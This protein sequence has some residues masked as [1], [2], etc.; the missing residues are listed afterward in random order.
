MDRRERFDSIEEAVRAFVGGAQAE[1]WTALPGVVQSFDAAERTCTVQ[2]AVQALARDAT[3]GN[4]TWLDLPLLLDCPVMFP[5]GG[6]VTLTFPVKQG[7]ECLVIF[8]SR[9]IDAW[10]QNG[11]TKNKQ[12]ILRMHD[13][14][15][16]FVFVGIRSKAVIAGRNVDTTRAMLTTDDGTAMVAITAETGLVEVHTDNDIDF[17]AANIRMKGNVHIEGDFST[18][19]AFTN[20]GKDV[21]SVHTHDK[22]RSG[23]ETSGGPT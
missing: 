1:L 21:G 8:A 14:S 11:G 3:S 4:K 13:L 6:G 22:V 10:W 23:G 5:S 9:C 17:V 7:D 16:G 15:D 20:N 12:A 19:G 2:P 18:E